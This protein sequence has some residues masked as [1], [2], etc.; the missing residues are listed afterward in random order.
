[1]RDKM[2]ESMPTELMKELRE[3]IEI[4]WGEEVPRKARGGGWLVA[5]VVALRAGSL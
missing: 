5:G 4:I 2:G 1:M 3:E